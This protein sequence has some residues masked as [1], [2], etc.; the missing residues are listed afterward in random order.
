M[1]FIAT[2]ENMAALQRAFTRCLQARAVLGAGLRGQRL[3]AFSSSSSNPVFELKMCKVPPSKRQDYLS[4]SQHHLPEK[5]ALAKMHG[6]WVSESWKDDAGEGIVASL[7]EYGQCGFI[8]YE[9][10]SLE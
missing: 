3:A 1:R 6:F 10:A 8:T 4:S 9:T 7:W 5:T 2:A